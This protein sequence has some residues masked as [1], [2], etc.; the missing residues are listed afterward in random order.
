MRGELGVGYNLHPTVAAA[1]ECIPCH[2]R[3]LQFSNCKEGASANKQRFYVK[4]NHLIKTSSK[5]Y[6]YLGCKTVKWI[7][8]VWYTGMKFCQMVQNSQTRANILW[9]QRPS[10]VI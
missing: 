4:M 9:P 5:L 6:Q 10:R 2:Y 7:I 8:N 1:A 3:L